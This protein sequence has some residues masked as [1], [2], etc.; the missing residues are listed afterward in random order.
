MSSIAIVS[1]T[2]VCTWT[3]QTTSRVAFFQVMNTRSL[4]RLARYDFLANTWTLYEFY[5]H[6][7]GI[8]LGATRTTVLYLKGVRTIITRETVLRQVG[9]PCDDVRRGVIT[10]R[11][12]TT[13]CT[14]L[15]IITIIAIVFT[16]GTASHHSRLFRYVDIH[17]TGGVARRSHCR[18]H[19]GIHTVDIVT[20]AVVAPRTVFKVVFG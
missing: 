11:P 1:F 17:L 4:N 9:L 14:I 15:L 3:K 7:I 8:K 19:W 10:E 16:Q 12:L 18:L 6:T 20:T 13:E 5:T 2:A